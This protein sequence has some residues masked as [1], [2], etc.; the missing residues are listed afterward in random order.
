MIIKVY[1]FEEDNETKM[2]MAS[3]SLSTIPP[4]TKGNTHTHAHAHS[5]S[6]LCSI[7][8]IYCLR[9]ETLSSAA[10]AEWFGVLGVK[11]KGQTEI[12]P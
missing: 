6:D 1:G 9:L 12:F 11:G 7:F 4:N 10:A 5:S 2:N 3:R 8:P